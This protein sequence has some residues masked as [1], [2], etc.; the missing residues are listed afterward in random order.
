M[1]L[2]AVIPVN[3]ERNRLLVAVERARAVPP[4]MELIW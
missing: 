1:R 3:I 4:E 2:S